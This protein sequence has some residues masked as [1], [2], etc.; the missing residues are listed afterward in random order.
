MK[1]KRLS[2]ILE[3]SPSL[4]TVAL[5]A[6]FGEWDDA[7]QLTTVET[8]QLVSVFPDSPVWDPENVLDEWWSDRACF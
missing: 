4:N 2:E 1:M 6:V 8:G 7:R 5:N 3:Q